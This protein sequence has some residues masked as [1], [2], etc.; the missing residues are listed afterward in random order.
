MGASISVSLRNARMLISESKALLVEALN[1]VKR[2]EF[3]KA[4]RLAQKAMKGLEEAADLLSCVEYKIWKE[5][6]PRWES[7]MMKF[8]L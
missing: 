1:A 6:C 8:S 7:M 5:A 2:G 3:D 4:E